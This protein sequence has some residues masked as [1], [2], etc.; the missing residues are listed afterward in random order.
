MYDYVTVSRHS[1]VGIATI[2]GLDDGQ[3]QEFSLL[4]AVQTGYGVHPTSYPMGTAGYFP[5]VKEAGA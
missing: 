5:G 2:Y 3:G 1:A 4:H